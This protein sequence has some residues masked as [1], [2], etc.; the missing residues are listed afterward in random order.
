VSTASIVRAMKKPR[1]CSPPGFPLGSFIALMME[2]VLASETSVYYNETALRSIQEG[3]YFY[4]LFSELYIYSSFMT[5]N[6]DVLTDELTYTD[7]GVLYSLKN[8][9]KCMSDTIFLQSRPH[10]FLNM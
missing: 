2:A 4:I 5:E 3:D 7:I 6:N 10:T 9:F 1:P 8:C